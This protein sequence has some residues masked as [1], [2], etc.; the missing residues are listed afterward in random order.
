M[1]LQ[2]LTLA[3]KFPT[4]KSLNVKNKHLRLNI[5]FTACAIGF[6]QHASA[7]ELS[8]E[9]QYEDVSKDNV[10]EIELSHKFDSGFK[11]AGTLKFKPHEQANGDSGKAF[12]DDRWHE[13]KISA[14]YSIQ[15]NDHWQLTP[16]VSW[17]RKQNAYKYKP[18][19]KLKT[20]ITDDTHASIRYRKEIT[21]A[22][23]KETKKV[24]RIDLG[25]SHK[26]EDV[27]LGYT[28]T[29]YHGNQNLFDKK[30]NDYQHEIE[31]AYKL[32][33]TFSPYIA[34]KNESVSSKT[35]QRQTEFDIGFTLK[36]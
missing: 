14:S 22:S 11:L 28:Y 27:T 13:S 33:K 23:G 20:A 2:T 7:T 24:D 17:S 34:V 15:L 16:G 21:D 26:I 35:D 9:H 8:Y 5:L 25:V 1:S 36:I 29:Y 32:T 18:S 19:L 6:I 10:D 30:R 4:K 12:H 31:A 3:P